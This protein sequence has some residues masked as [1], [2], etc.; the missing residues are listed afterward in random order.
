VV[1]GLAFVLLIAPAA[2]PAE[3]RTDTFDVGPLTVGGY[4]VQQS[5][6]VAPHPNLGAAEHGFITRMEVDV[7][8]ENGTP[9]PIQRLMLHHIVFANLS[10]PDETCQSITGFDGTLNPG[11]ARERFFAAGEER[12]RMTLPPGYGYRLD[13]SD[14]W[15]LL[16]MFMNHR[17]QTDTA[18]IRYTTTTVTG[19]DAAQIKRVDP[20]WLDVRNCHAD[21]I[22]NVPGNK[23]PGST[24]TRSYE[25]AMP[26]SG[27]VIAGG[28]HVHGGARMLTLSQPDCGDRE[29]ARSEPTWGAPDH[30][31]YNVKPILHEPGPINMT[32]FGTQS[33]FPV[34]AGQRLRLDSLY[35]NSLPHTR[36]MGIMVV[37]VDP[38]D[39]GDR[40][41]DVAPGC[42][43]LPDDVGY[44]G[45]NELGRGGPIPYRIPLT[46]LNENGDAVTIKNPPGKIERMRSGS[47][48]FVGDRFFVNR[49]VKVKRGARLTWS[50]G[51]EQLHNVTLA[52]GPIG[53][54]SDNLDGD[55]TFEQELRKKGNYRFFCALHPVEMTQRVKVV[56]KHKRNRRR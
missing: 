18:Y 52:N 9:I 11:L 40:T 20:Y 39:P 21:P 42:A 45:G 12:A 47:T 15:G 26:Q 41:D 6:A 56:G 24:H 1:A 7:V 3:V 8:D 14:F 48:L 46:G 19:S 53:I 17:A 16:Y 25:L 36:V 28:G 38:D 44:V 22:Y 55:R 34:A 54:G 4:E 50:F 30:P 27:R 31:F 29:L 13:D 35:D 32:A 49:N 37:Y 43:P 51:T 10:R 2:A 33:G 23:G 5:F